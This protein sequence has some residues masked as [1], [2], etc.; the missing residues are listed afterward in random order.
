MKKKRSR[1]K[2]QIRVCVKCG[3]R[4][5]VRSDN[6]SDQCRSCAC[7]VAGA[8]GIE[9]IRKRRLQLPCSECGQIFNT[10]PSAERRRDFRF[11]S[12][13]CRKRHRQVERTCKFCRQAFHVSKGRLSDKTNS[14]GNFC[15]RPCYERWL[16]NTDKITG[17]GSRWKAIRTE[18]IRRF[19][20]CAKCGTTQRLDVHHIIPFRLTRDNGQ[21]NLIPLCKK[22]HKLVETVFHDAE[23]AVG[24]LNLLKL[25]FWSSLKERQLATRAYLKSL[26]FGSNDESE[27]GTL[28]A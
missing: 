20:F 19:P 15:S 2:P 26:L 9:T 27:S 10:I 17:R 5:E 4:E 11:C 25:F 16:C 21:S 7:R 14:S 22:C 3:K 28:A 6:K 23:L 8:K 13:H 12:W 18:A 24:N 1:G